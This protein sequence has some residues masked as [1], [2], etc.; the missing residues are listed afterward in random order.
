MSGPSGETIERRCSLGN[1]AVEELFRRKTAGK[2][3]AAEGR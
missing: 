2:R 1:N 3:P